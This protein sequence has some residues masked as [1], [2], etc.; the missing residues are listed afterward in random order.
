MFH[1]RAHGAD[2]GNVL[3]GFQLNDEDLDAFN[4]HLEKLG[5]VYQDVTESPAYRYFLV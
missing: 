1:Y 5:Y 3:A 4:Q 2:Y